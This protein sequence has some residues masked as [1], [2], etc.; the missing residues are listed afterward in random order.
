[1]FLV[2]VGEVRIFVFVCSIDLCTERELSALG[3]PS[4]D[5]CKPSLPNTIKFVVLATAA[6]G[7]L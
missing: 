1:M 5:L 7:L 4:I 2:E 3:T 6:L